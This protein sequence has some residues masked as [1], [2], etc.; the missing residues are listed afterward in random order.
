M[1]FS[2]FYM[3]N[4][5]GL[6]FVGEVA[7]KGIEYFEKGLQD[8]FFLSED[9]KLSEFEQQVHEEKSTKII[10]AKMPEEYTSSNNKNQFY[11]KMLQEDIDC[12]NLKK[13]LSIRHYTDRNKMYYIQIS[14]EMA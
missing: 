14:F 10:F 8:I 4:I 5:S 7:P 9:Q 1:K 12:E 11:R 6:D 3:K 2:N 13:V